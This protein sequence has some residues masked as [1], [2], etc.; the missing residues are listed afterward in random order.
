M[1]NPFKNTS[2][3]MI[4]AINGIINEQD[5]PQALKTLNV[6]GRVAQ[7]LDF[8][9]STDD[10][11]VYLKGMGTMP[12]STVKKL[13]KMDLHKFA[14]RVG[15]ISSKELLSVLTDVEGNMKSSPYGNFAYRIRGL[16]EVEDFMNRPETKRKISMMKKKSGIV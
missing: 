8:T 13:V 5:Q 1:N 12:L 6:G 9:M 15:V 2:K 10:P 16:A 3:E 4:D 14:D 11:D 7:T